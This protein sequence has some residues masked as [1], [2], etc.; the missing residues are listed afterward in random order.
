[1]VTV[2]TFELVAEAASRV[3]DFS[4]N[5]KFLLYRD[6]AGLP[7][8]LNFGEGGQALA[9]ADPPLHA[10][11]RDAV[12]PELVAKRMEALEPDILEL[13]ESWSPELWRPASSSS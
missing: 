3:E 12:F 2:S 11:H 6:D 10:I 8:R 4:S 5:M 9:T 1:M 7:A 13:A